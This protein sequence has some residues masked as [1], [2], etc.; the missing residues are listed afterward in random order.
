M[1]DPAGTQKRYQ[2]DALGHLTRVTEESSG[3][4]YA[5]TYAYACDPGM[6][7]SCTRTAAK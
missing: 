1:T 3:L 4:A 2:M 5:T 7:R 6:W